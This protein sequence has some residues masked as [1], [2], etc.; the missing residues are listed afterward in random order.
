MGLSITMLLLPLFCLRLLAVA[1]F[2]AIC[3]HC[4]CIT[5]PL[6]VTC[7]QVR[8]RSITSQVLR[9]VVRPMRSFPNVLLINTL[10]AASNTAR[11]P[12]VAVMAYPFRLLAKTSSY[13]PEHH[14]S[15]VI[16]QWFPACPSYSL[17]NQHNS[18]LRV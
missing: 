11:P 2:P 3:C 18:V 10:Q 4:F 15:Y 17:E 8:L 13:K 14:I 5:I 12:M 7:S 9:A 16:D 1:A 6:V